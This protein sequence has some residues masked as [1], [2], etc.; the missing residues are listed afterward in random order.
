M[1]VQLFHHHL[2]KKGYFSSIELLLYLVKNQ[3]N[4]VILACFST[5]RLPQWLRYMFLKFWLTHVN[6]FLITHIVVIIIIIII[7]KM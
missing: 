7:I 5:L 3:L 2:L 6:H 4:V 1:N